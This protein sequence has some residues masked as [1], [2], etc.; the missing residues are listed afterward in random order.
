MADMDIYQQMAERTDGNIYVGVVGPVRTGKSTFIRRFMDLMVLPE[1]EE[2]W[3]K[4]RLIDELPQSGGGRTI[5][6]T[7]ISFV[8]S[9]AVEVNL[10]DNARCSV[11]MVDC[12]GYMVDGAYGDTENGQ[13]R[14]VRTPWLDND[15]PFAQAAEMGTRKVIEDHSTIGLVVTTDGSITDI[16]RAG[17]VPAE[18][19]AVG[20]LKALGKPFIMLLNSR[21]PMSEQ[22]RDL[23]D[24]LSAKYSVPVIA[25]DALRMSREDVQGIIKTVLYEFPIRQVDFAMPQWV[26]SLPWGHWLLDFVVNVVKESA[27][28]I[29]KVK[30]YEDLVA[31]FALAENIQE[32][33]VTQIHAGS[34]VVEAT[35]V[36]ED[37]LYY[38]LL[39][40]ES[41]ME[42]N[43]EASLMSIIY[44]LAHAKRE[45]DKMADALE[46]VKERGYGHVRPGI[47][48]VKLDPP[49]LVRQGGRF[50][51][52]FRATA[53][54]W[55][56]L[57]V[58]LS[59]EVTQTI[60][61]EKQAEDFNRRLNDEFE[62]DPA[63]LWNT[64]FF[65]TTLFDMISEGLEHKS[66]SL[67]TMAQ[68]RMRS[69]LNRMVNDGKNNLIC[70]LF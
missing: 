31:A 36:P 56:M 57:R 29:M 22:A 46:N 51:I 20:E 26:Q 24:Q 15:V 11:R 33:R 40:E 67:P 39:S 61:S 64:D 41:G 14:M 55:H 21:A 1:L 2:S 65:G 25:M 10:S 23:S 45:Y 37:S 17:Y 18:E 13:P 3:H 5:M 63:S 38:R 69:A 47:K 52:R 53:P 8:P 44:D 30:D 68:T 6:T 50:S 28:A 19:R 58:D 27:K 35:I 60:G 49:E 34:G 12:V 42:I 9:E 70:I 66:G 54:S 62:R 7:Q 32:L 48:D 43:D 59:A 4:E 16:P